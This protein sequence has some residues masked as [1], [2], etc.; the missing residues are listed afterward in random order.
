MMQSI[1]NG[2]AR[3]DGAAG[4]GGRL[5]LDERHPLLGIFFYSRLSTCLGKIPVG[6]P[7]LPT[8]RHP[9]WKLPVYPNSGPHCLFLACR[10]HARPQRER[11]PPHF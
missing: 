10:T 9:I 5:T 1:G 4:Q 6:T 8:S 2:G 3:R 11:I 7:P